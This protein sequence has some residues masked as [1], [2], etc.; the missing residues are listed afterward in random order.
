MSERYGLGII[1]GPFCGNGH[2]FRQSSGN[3]DPVNE[4]RPIA[5]NLTFEDMGLTKHCTMYLP[6]SNK[7]FYSKLLFY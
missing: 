7:L 2:I 1:L 6:E 3:P 5:K 4:C